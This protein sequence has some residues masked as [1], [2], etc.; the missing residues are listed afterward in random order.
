MFVYD[1]LLVSI[2]FRH[3]VLY[4][5]VCVLFSEYEDADVLFVVCVHHSAMDGDH[6]RLAG[7]LEEIA[8]TCSSVIKTEF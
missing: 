5:S 8:N 6:K 4:V 3:S 1:Q 7:F 2:W